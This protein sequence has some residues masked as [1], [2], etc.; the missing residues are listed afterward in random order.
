MPA[1]TSTS[2]SASVSASVSVDDQSE[3]AG[4]LQRGCC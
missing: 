2:L 3:R 4:D 1:S